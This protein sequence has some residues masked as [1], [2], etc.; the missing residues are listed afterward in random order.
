MKSPDRNN[1][2]RSRCGTEWCVIRVSLTQLHEELRDHIRTDLGH[3]IQTPSMQEGQIPAQI[4][5]IGLDRVRGQSPLNNQM[6]QVNLNGTGDLV[7]LLGVQAKA[8]L[9][10]WCSSPCD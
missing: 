1:G 7:P 5:T 4:T 9:I 8:S 3:V 2:S 10:E 6:I